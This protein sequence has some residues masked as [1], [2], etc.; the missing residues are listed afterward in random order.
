M[1]RI[2]RIFLCALTS[3][4]LLCVS[5][6]VQKKDSLRFYVVSR[7]QLSASMSASETAKFV[8]ENGRLAFDGDD[9]EGYNWQ[10][11]TVFLK[12]E[13]VPSVGIVTSESGGSAVFKSDDT[14]AF[15]L[16]LDGNMLYYG[17]FKSGVKNPDVPL[18]PSVEDSGRYSFQIT[19]DGKYATGN[20][21]RSDNRLYEFLNSQ[22]LLS[23]KTE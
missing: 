14:Y 16:L 23:S 15:V 20:D 1:K 8:R 9:I 6:S 19:F 5:C 12:E 2:S 7:S 17:G 10:T 22:G 13:A 11:H 21:P 4:L 3:A 18:Q